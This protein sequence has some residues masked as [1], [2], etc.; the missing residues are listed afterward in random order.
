LVTLKNTLIAFSEGAPAIF[1]DES[2]SCRVEHCDFFGNWGNF[3]YWTSP[4][5]D[6]PPNLGVI[7]TMNANGDSCDTYMNIYLAPLLRD[8]ENEDYHLMW[9]ECGDSADSPC[10]DAGDPTIHD[11]TLDCA[12]GL[13]TLISDI[14]LYG[15]DSVISGISYPSAPILP[16]KPILF[17]NFPNPFNPITQIQFD[18]P[19]AAQ[20]Q[21]RI[22]NI[23]GQEVVT[24]ANGIFPAG[25]HGVSWNATNFPSGIYIYQFKAE[26]FMEAKKMVLIR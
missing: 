11:H 13:G 21:L 9:T 16:A 14:G 20:V 15:G 19:K 5:E 7:D 17:Q 24:L 23:L 22:Y 10:I 8:I 25:T 4:W 12:W 6:A 26:D 1:F 18:L 2:P 3:D